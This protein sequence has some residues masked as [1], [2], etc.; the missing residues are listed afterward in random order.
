MDVRFAALSALLANINRDPKKTSAFKIEDFLIR[1]GDDPGK[2]RDPSWQQ[3]KA[4]LAM[5][6][7]AYTK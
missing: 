1:F 5:A 6:M 3:M 7:E 2:R 4:M